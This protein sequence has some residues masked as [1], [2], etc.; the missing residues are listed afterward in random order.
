MDKYIFICTWL[1]VKLNL[2]NFICVAMFVTESS[3][4]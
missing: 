1:Y 4:R 2:M 3:E